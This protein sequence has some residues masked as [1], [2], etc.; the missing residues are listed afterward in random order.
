MCVMQYIII[1]LVMFA[2]LHMHVIY[3]VHEGHCTD[4]QLYN[5]V[6]VLFGEVDRFVWGRSFK[7]RVVVKQPRHSTDLWYRKWFKSCR[8]TFRQS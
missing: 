1:M 7:V 2:I 4:L 3:N 5:T 6:L 8:D